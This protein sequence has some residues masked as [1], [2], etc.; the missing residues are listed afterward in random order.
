MDLDRDGQ[1]DVITGSWPGRIH[2]FPGSDGGSFARGRTLRHAD[3]TEIEPGRAS[4]AFAADWNADGHVDLLVGNIAGAIVWLPGLASESAPVFGPALPIEVEGKPLSVGNDGAPAVADWDGDGRADL[5]VGDGH[6]AVQWFRNTGA[7]IPELARPL[8]LI[9]APVATTRAKPGEP[10]PIRGN[11]ARFCVT[12][13]NEDGHLDLLVGEFGSGVGQ[14]AKANG[15][16]REDLERKGNALREAIAA[17]ERAP[18]DESPED[19]E[20]RIQRRDALC[21][22][23]VQIDEQLSS[24]GSTW[25]GRVWL[26]QRTTAQRTGEAR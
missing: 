17:A 6:G 25:L 11:R 1:R 19:R 7:S 10:R 26:F 24:A 2:W 18:A 21:A 12:D 15:A 13:W 9:Q 5:L 8:T 16:E 14:A 3:G 23:W 22:E 20:A 4:A